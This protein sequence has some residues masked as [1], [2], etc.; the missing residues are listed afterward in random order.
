MVG[1]SCTD[2]SP[3]NAERVKAA[4]DGLNRGARLPQ[5]RVDNA[6][7]PGLSPFLLPRDLG[8]MKHLRHLENR[9]CTGGAIDVY[10]VT[11]DADALWRR[12]LRSDDELT[13]AQTEAAGGRIRYVRQSGFDYDVEVA[14]SE[15]SELGTLLARRSCS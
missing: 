10:A 9:S 15:G 4:L 11:R 3:T 7:V 6:S 12:M 1:V 8:G 13:T 2:D 14:L 5:Q